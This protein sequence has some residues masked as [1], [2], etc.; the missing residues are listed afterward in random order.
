MISKFYVILLILIT[1]QIV[2]FPA[3]EALKILPPDDKEE[4]D[5][6]RCWEFYYHP[7]HG[8]IPNICLKHIQTIMS[9]VNDGAS[10]C[11]CNGEGSMSF[12]CSKLGGQCECKPNVIGLHCDMCAPG[13][14]GFGPEGCTGMSLHF[15]HN[16]FCIKWKL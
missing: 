9:G 11:E 12:E 4:F 13:T 15:D 1:L 16:E 3:S 6:Y 10:A 8:H 14:F 5:R 7:G 2:I